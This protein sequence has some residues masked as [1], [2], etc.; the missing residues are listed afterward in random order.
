M[1]LTS[2]FGRDTS[3]TDRLRPGRV[4]SGKRL[5]AEAVYRRLTT[6]RGTLLYDPNYG[7][8][9]VDLLGAEITPNQEAA[10]PSRIKNELMKDG[11]IEDVRVSL[12]KSGAAYTVEIEVE[13][14]AGPFDLVLS[15]SDLTTEIL[16]Q[17]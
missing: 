4:V 11:R 13:C 17:P 1:A 10:L 12:S 2:V 14:A 6:T 3:C 7:L 16:R 5:V 8:A 15:V 9:L